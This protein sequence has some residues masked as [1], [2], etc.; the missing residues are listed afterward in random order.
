MPTISDDIVELEVIAPQ[1]GKRLVERLQI[2]SCMPALGYP[3]PRVLVELADGSMLVVTRASIDL[4]GLPINTKRI[5]RG[6]RA[7]LR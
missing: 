5:G 7:R 3:L 4:A 6:R 2:A 1:A